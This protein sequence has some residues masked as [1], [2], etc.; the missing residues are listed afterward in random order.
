MLLFP[1]RN[2]QWWPA[3]QPVPEMEPGMTGAADGD[4]ELLIIIIGLPVMN[5]HSGV[6]TAN[7][8]VPVASQDTFA[9]AAEYA[10]D[11]QSAR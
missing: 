7:L 5:A 6:A 11:R 2:Q 4:E 8:T 1:E 3:G 9:I 10:R